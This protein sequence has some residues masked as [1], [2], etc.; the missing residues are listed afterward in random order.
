MV[1]TKMLSIRV[2]LRA[3]NI[4]DKRKKNHRVLQ[5]EKNI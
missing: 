3:N 4:L 1:D 5:K 2:Q